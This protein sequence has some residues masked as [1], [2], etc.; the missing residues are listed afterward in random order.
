MSSQFLGVATDD[1]FEGEVL[2]SEKP[3]LI[4][5]WAPWCGPCKAIGPIVEEIAAQYQDKVKVMKLNVDD[6]QKAAATYG[7]RSIPTLMMFKGGKVLDTMIGL[8]PK[9][10]LEEFVKKSL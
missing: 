4:D 2:K 5:F 9:E 10:K 3:V 1:N 7:V 8:V 6:A